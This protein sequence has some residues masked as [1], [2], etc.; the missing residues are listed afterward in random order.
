MVVLSLG[1]AVARADFSDLA[2]PNWHRWRGPDATGVA[3]QGNPPLHW[4][5]ETNIK[6]K[7]DVEGR[8]NSSPIVWG[9][10]IFVLT[11]VDTGRP[12]EAAELPPEVVEAKANDPDLDKDK[13]AGE[14]R[15]PKNIHQLKVICFLRSTGQR[16]WERVAAEVTPREKLHDTNTY[17]SSSPTTDGQRVYASFGSLGIYCYDLD[18]NPLWQ[19]DFGDINTENEFGE[20]SSPT[21]HEG[22]LIVNYDQNGPCFITALDAAT[23]KP[24]W[25]RD[26]P[27]EMTS[28]NTPIVVTSG[29][30]TQVVV[31][32][33]L[34]RGYDIT[35][36]DVIWEC[37]GQAKL[38]IASPVALGDVVYCMT[39]FRGNAVY[40]IPLDAVGD[41]TG[42]DKVVWHTDASGPYV[43]SPILYGDRLYFTKSS[44]NVISCVDAH[45][46]KPYIDQKRVAG[47]DKQYASPVGAAGRI[48]FTGRDGTTVAIRHADELEVLATN[49]L[50]EDVDATPAIVGNQIFIRGHEHLYCISEE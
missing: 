5:A 25:K 4:D 34:S 48:Y 32:G 33:K 30:R 38:A 17:A 15:V 49:A 6:W 11:A 14:P 24:K 50:G 37:G 42:T 7:V 45:T 9:D 2:A 16:L 36:G 12:G 39:G 43:P 22:T 47:L 35:N 46:G 18:G 23:G 28:W 1:A 29:G 3:P 10:R 44:S 13:D 40:A 19:R 20:G 21:I 26:R 41:I 27:D 8:A 31:N